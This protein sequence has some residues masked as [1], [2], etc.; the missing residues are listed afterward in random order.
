[1]RIEKAI[2]ISDAKI[3]FVSLV[4]KAANQRQFLITKAE[5]GMGNFS[6]LGKILKVDAETHYIT[7]IV[8]EPL[9]EDIHG[10]FMTEEE[11]R[12]AAHWFAKNG[13]KVDLQHSFEAVDGVS[14]VETYIAPSDITIG[15]ET[16]IKGTWLMTAEVTNNEVWE[17]V[18]KGEVTG[19]SMG[20]VGKYSEKDVELEP[21]VASAGE[22]GIFKKFA[23]LLGYELIKKGEV[24][25]K[26]VSSNK[27]SS[28]WNAWYALDD[29]L[30]SY[31]WRTDGW[32]FESDTVK[33][34]EALGDFSE[35]LTALL[36]EED[37]VKSLVKSAK[38]A[39][40]PIIKAGKK[41][42]GENYST[43]QN[44][45]NNIGDLLTKLTDEDKEDDSE[46][47][48]QEIQAMIAEAITKAANPATPA[49][50]DPPAPELTAEA[51]QTMIAKAVQ[52][53]LNPPAE[54]LTAET[55]QATVQKMVAE[56]IEPVLKARGLA[57]NLNGEGSVTKSG[58]AHYLTGII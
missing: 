24:K 58:E 27:S 25:D 19:F 38:D 35:I 7:G 3:S 39:P 54:P 55:I 46:V 14:V 31:D 5:D 53:A 6:S 8:Y 17:K 26:Y 29:T 28:F 30:R 23:G 33:I 1:M 11:I 13:D 9:V 45:H 50:T 49:A 32:V 16:V 43:L 52:D 34:K 40:A 47:N 20:G 18:Q 57:N 12:K 4:D 10:N 48:K 2:E 21:I 44:I 51:V 42:S 36:T 37:V 41:I 56:A 15:E 22:T